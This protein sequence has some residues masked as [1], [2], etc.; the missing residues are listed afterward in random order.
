MYPATGYVV[1]AKPDKKDDC[2]AL[3]ENV[4]IA[5]AAVG[6]ITSSRQLEIEYENEIACVFDFERDIITGIK[7][8]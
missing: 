2:I 6:V 8:Y 1:T 7:P 5:A 4:G 3:F